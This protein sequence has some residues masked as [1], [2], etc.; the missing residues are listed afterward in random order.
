MVVRV[1]SPVTDPSRK[2]SA[3]AGG[4]SA[5]LVIV[6]YM[7]RDR[8]GLD[9]PADVIAAGITAAFGAWRFALWLPKAVASAV[10]HQFTEHAEHAV[11][12]HTASDE[13][14][15][16]VQ[17]VFAAEASVILS[18]LRGMRTTVNRVDRRQ[19]EALGLQ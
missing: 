11:L 7:V 9:I 19:R 4:G 18:E 16:L 14:K 3:A 13:F 6:T 10:S 5:L 2:Q 17:E 1:T 15:A 12:V 8:L